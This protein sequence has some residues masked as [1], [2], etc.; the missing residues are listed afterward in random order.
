MADWT[1]KLALAGGLVLGA[2]GSAP[3]GESDRV[4]ATTMPTADFPLTTA[5]ATPS[6]GLQSLPWVLMGTSPDHKTL[7]LNIGVGGGC[8]TTSSELAVQEGDHYVRITSAVAEAGGP[9]CAASLE[10]SDVRVVLANP[11]GERTL[12]HAPLG[13]TGR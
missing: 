11:L 2:C 12:V 13:L 8:P 10:T 3:P 4:T 5:T 7:Y 1:C 6:P 9:D